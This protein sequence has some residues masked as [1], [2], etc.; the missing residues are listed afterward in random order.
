MAGGVDDTTSEAVRAWAPAHENYALSAVAEGTLM[1]VDQDVTAEWAEHLAAA[2]PRALQLL[3]A[4]SE[5]QAR[6]S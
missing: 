2:W 5:S 1:R 4:L 6:S 3:K